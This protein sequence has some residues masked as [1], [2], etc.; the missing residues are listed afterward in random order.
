MEPFLSRGWCRIAHRLIRQYPIQGP[1]SLSV[2]VNVT[3]MATPFSEPHQ[4]RVRFRKGRVRWNLGHARN[5]DLTLT[6]PYSVAIKMWLEGDSMAG[7]EA[8]YRG[9]LKFT[10]DYNVLVALGR[11][12][13]FA[14][15]EQLLEQLVEIT[16]S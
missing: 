12:T 14:S 8:L 10:G 3:V 5:A 7:E 4:L 13:F 15:N 2:T 1:P 11:W 9:D 16:G 6:F